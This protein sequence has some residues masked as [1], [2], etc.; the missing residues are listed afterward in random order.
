MGTV[1]SLLFFCVPTIGHAAEVHAFEYSLVEYITR[2][3]VALALLIALGYAVT[4]YF[5]KHFT[6]LQPQSRL[7][8][9]GVL[10]LGKDSLY[11]VK[12][13]PLVI[14]LLLGKETRVLAQWSE[15][16]WEQYEEHSAP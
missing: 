3:S 6:A 2:M 15:E 8:V 13:G 11:I 16:E 12:T 9:L 5:P 1:F 4:R 14:A 7:K 10:R